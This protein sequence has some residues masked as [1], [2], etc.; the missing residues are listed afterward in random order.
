MPVCEDAV[1][2]LRDLKKNKKKYGSSSVD[3]NNAPQRGIIA[4]LSF[5]KR[6]SSK[7]RANTNASSNS[8][9]QDPC[10]L[11]I[12]GDL[13]TG[14]S[15]DKWPNGRKHKIVSKK[16]VLWI[17]PDSLRVVED[18]KKTLLTDQ[19]IEKVSF[20]A[21]DRHFA[22]SFSYICRDGTTRKWWCYTFTARK[23]VSGERLSHAVG[24]AFTACLKRKL[25]LE[26]H[27]KN[28]QIEAQ[29][30]EVGVDVGGG[31]NDGEIKG[32]TNLVVRSQT[33]PVL[34]VADKK[35]Q[36]NASMVYEKDEEIRAERTKILVE[37]KH[38]ELR[39][40][41]RSRP[42]RNPGGSS[43]GGA[44]GS[45]STL[46]TPVTN[47]APPIIPPQPQ[48]IST[49]VTAQPPAPLIPPSSAIIQPNSKNSG[50]DPL[51]PQKTIDELLAQ[52]PTPTP[53]TENKILGVGSPGNWNPWDSLNTSNPISNG[54]VMVDSGFQG[55]SSGFSRNNMVKQP[56]TQLIMAK[57]PGSL[58]SSNNP[59]LQDHVPVQTGASVG[60]PADQWLNEITNSGVSKQP[61]DNV[62]LI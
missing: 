21:P 47:I 35:L 2:E 62:I 37:E 55:Q 34:N 27:A 57:S 17:S 14:P 15:T 39:K 10:S 23:N 52:N 38:P 16:A 58:L 28:A 22:K 41:M 26:K 48:A 56:P 59:F 1:K 12:E 19:T 11:N 51:Q 45:A 49:P 18:K 33:E 42:K 3:P 29:E 46:P 40:S 25:D 5:R 30:N 13:I 8:G 36:K 7:S 44:G 43:G 31:L 6:N 4:R 50:F 20:C 53:S 60:T 32:V 54:N 61:V 9:N 24:C